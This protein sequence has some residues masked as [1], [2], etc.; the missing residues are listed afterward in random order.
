MIYQ[1]RNIYDR[2]FWHTSGGVE[3]IHFGVIDDYGNIVRG[4]PYR[5]F[6]NSFQLEDVQTKDMSFIY[7]YN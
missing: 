3:A 2:R 6:A 7:D 5:H 4:D 1:M